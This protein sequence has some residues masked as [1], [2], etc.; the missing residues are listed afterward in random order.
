MGSKKAN[1][2]KKNKPN[3][4]SDPIPPAAQD[5][6]SHGSGAGKVITDSRFAAVNSDP[7]FQKVP[8]HKSKVEIDSRFNRIFTD[9]S[10]GSSSAPVDKRG[11]PKKQNSE[12]FLRHY[13]RIEE[14][15]EEEE[16]TEEEEDVEEERKGQELAKL[17]GE[18]SETEPSGES[19]ASESEDDD[20]DVENWESDSTDDTDEDE[21]F[22]VDYEPEAPVFC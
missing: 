12:N 14:K 16:E 9:K 7:R 13:Y 20:D 11:K 10:F 1:K 5:S 18:E 21:E 6:N 8:K 4:D 15:S 22:H 17:G 2:N 19:G 3:K